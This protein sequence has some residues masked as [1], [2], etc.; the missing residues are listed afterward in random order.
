MARFICFVLAMVM[1]ICSVPALAEPADAAKELK[2][3]FTHDIH[4]YFDITKAV[5]GGGVREHGGAGRLKTLLDQNRDENTLYLDAGDFSMGTLLQAGYATDAY[6]LRLLGLLGCDA[7]TFGNHEFDLGGF[8]AAQMLKSAMASGD[9]LP[10]FVQSNMILT[11]DLTDE[12][13]ALAEAMHDYGAKNYIIR[14]VNG[15]K[16]GIFGLLGIDGIECAPTSGMNFRDY[17]EAAKTTVAAIKE[18][19]ADVIICLSHCGTDGDGAN[20]E[21]F[22]LAKAVPDINVIISGH[23]HTTYAEPILCGSTIIVSAGEYLANLG[24]ITLN[25]Q[26]GAVSLTDYALIPCDESVPEDPALSAVYDT[27]KQHVQETYLADENCG[28]DDV[29]CHSDFDFMP[30]QEM[31]DTHQEYPMGNLIA[32][33]YLYEARRNGITDIDVAL[34]GLGTIR[35]SFFEGDITTADAFEICS[36]GMGADGSAGHPILSAYI[37]G[38]ELK[39]LVELDASL[40]PAVSSIKMSYSGLNYTFNTRRVLL[41]RVT[42]LHIIGQHGRAKNIRDDKLYKVCCNMYAANMLGMLNGLTGGILSIVPKYADGTPVEDFYTCSLKNT[43]G[44]EIK[45]WVAFKNYLS[46]FPEKD[47]VPAIPERYAKPEGRKVKVRIGGFASVKNGGFSTNLVIALPWL[48]IIGI[49]VLWFT[50]KK[51]WSRR[52]RRKARRIARKALHKEQKAA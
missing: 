43:E 23:S 6:E 40:G 33:S 10:Q 20:G 47:G 41:D 2:I 42:S 11:G 7:T 50:R 32:D 16:A 35:G 25:V 38:K 28:Y 15:L 31:Y 24:S 52:L 22:D 5:I 9:P 49:A 48:I 1:V 36:L 13:Q 46:S 29:I 14:E 26:N 30:L 37:T 18:E 4:S 51:R 19:G 21:D 27:F 8:G 3:L 12:Q 44:R 45:E 17:I 34:V 39:L